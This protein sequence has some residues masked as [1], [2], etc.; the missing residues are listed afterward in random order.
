[1]SVASNLHRI[2]P[3]IFV[4]PREFDSPFA[5]IESAQ[6]FLGL[7]LEVVDDA[8]QATNNDLQVE[9]EAESRRKDALRLV[10]YKLDKLEQHLGSSRRLLNDLRTLRRLLLDERS[11]SASKA[12]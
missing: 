11:S 4:L 3:E 2:N 6:E 9:A 7:L 1:V 10:L 5:S 12:S 8:K